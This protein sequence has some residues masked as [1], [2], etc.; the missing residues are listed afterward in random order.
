MSVHSGKLPTIYFR[1]ILAFVSKSPADTRRLLQGT[2]INQKSLK[3]LDSGFSLADYQTLLKNV[4]AVSKDPAVML[5]AGYRLPITTHGALSNAIAYSP[6]R[7]AMLKVITQFIGLRG[8]FVDV[9]INKGSTRTKFHIE[10]D[11]VLGEQKDSALDF[12]LSVLMRSMMYLELAPMSLPTIHLTR[13]KPTEHPRYER[14][15][16]ARLSYNQPENSVIFYTSELELPLPT[17]DAE[18]FELAV[19]KCR[20]LY[21]H[22]NQPDSIRKAIEN[23]LE[24]SPGM[25]WSIDLVAEKL[26]FSSRTVQRKL[27]K[28]NTNYQQVLDDWLKQLADNYLRAEGLS[29]E[30][31]AMLLGYNDGASFRR[32]F[33]R[34]YACSPQEY[35]QKLTSAD[36]REVI[37]SS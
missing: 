18:L 37:F 6:T 19:R 12:I 30:A 3:Q 33:K 17:Y 11:P 4:K 7:M 32:A 28:E 14:A 29:V 15:W 10:L 34:W 31:S 26:N 2:N 13:G 22:E 36:S 35:R 24:A 1:M 27:K 5:D 23:I 9:K 8:F 21:H 16:G 25:L 20:D